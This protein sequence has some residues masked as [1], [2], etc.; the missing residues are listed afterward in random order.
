MHNF[1][2]RASHFSM[3]LHVVTKNLSPGANIKS[4]LVL[5]LLLRDLVTWICPGISD[6]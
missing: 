4:G 1:N 3:A 5:N 6:G 2:A